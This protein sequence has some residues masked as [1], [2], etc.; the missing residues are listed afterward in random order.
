MHR[1]N[2]TIGILLEHMYICSTELKNA[3]LNYREFEVEDELHDYPI[4][5][6]FGPI[7]HNTS[8]TCSKRVEHVGIE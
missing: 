4:G 5:G 3:C 2:I 7:Y 8:K 1:Y 6:I